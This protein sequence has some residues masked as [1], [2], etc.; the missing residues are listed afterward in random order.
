MTIPTEAFEYPQNAGKKTDIMI[1]P[2]SIDDETT[3]YGTASFLQNYAKEFDLP[4]APSTNYI[5]KDHTTG[6][7][8]LLAARERYIFYQGLKDHNDE[9]K[10]LRKTLES[11]DKY[12]HED[13][14]DHEASLDAGESDSEEENATA[15]GSKQVTF[16]VKCATEPQ[17]KN[18][19]G[20]GGT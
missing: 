20:H 1:L 6:K 13:I 3:T 12:I 18:G 8:N 19:E 7:F 4:C 10:L 2:L 11:N 16:K 15:S 9:M 14:H 17:R 5:P